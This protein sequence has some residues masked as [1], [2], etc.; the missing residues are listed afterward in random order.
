REATAKEEHFWSRQRA[1]I[2]SRIAEREKHQRR[3]FR[4]LA[5]AATAAIVAIGTF[6][7]SHRTV[8][9]PPPQTGHE[10]VDPDQE[11]LV[12]VEDAV[13]NGGRAALEPAALL[14]EEINRHAVPVE[15]PRVHNK[16]IRD[17]N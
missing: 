15:K 7:T 17:A 10:Q 1:A 11:R 6:L 9:L 14:A 5:L 3:L 16:E 8:P 13:E 4:F 2:W 12:A